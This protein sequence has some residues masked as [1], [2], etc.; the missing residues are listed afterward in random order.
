MEA[1]RG[2]GAVGSLAVYAGEEGKGEVVGSVG[3]G[4]PGQRQESG[5]LEEESCYMQK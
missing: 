3:E 2:D 4:V 1:V 5:G